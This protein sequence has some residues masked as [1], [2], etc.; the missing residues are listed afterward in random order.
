MSDQAAKSRFRISVLSVAVLM[1]LAAPSGL[2]AQSCALCYQA[3]ANSGAN[4][5]EAL[6]RGILILLFPPLLIG[7]CIVITAYRKRHRYAED[8]S[9]PVER[10]SILKGISPSC[11]SLVYLKIRFSVTRGTF[12]SQ[13]ELAFPQRDAVNLESLDRPILQR[14][15]FTRRSRRFVNLIRVFA[16]V[17][18][19]ALQEESNGDRRREKNHQDQQ[20]CQPRPVFG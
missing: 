9:I 19:Q 4:F 12:G 2:Y 5:I 1:A 18:A 13:H 8:W 10:L 16:F 6:K 20:R 14:S 17:S 3:A 11:F 7:S 15:S